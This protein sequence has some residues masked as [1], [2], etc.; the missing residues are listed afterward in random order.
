MLKVREYLEN[1]VNIIENLLQIKVKIDTE[2]VNESEFTKEEKE[3]NT[4]PPILR[5]RWEVSGVDWISRVAFAD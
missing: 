5:G 2:P 3:N 4:L 1:K